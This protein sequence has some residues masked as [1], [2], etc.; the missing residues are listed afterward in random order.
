MGC[1]EWRVSRRS[2]RAGGS[3]VA[4][5]LS[6]LAAAGVAA[7]AASGATAATAST[8][9]PFV[10][11]GENTCTGEAFNAAGKLHLVLGESVSASGNVQSHLHATLRGVE[12]TT[13]TGAKYV[14]MTSD[15]MTYTFDALDLAPFV[16][17]II[18]TVQY[19]RSG[20]DGAVLK[21]DDFYQQIVAHVTVNS[22]GV[23]TV[24]RFTFDTRCR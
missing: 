24:D 9:A 23:V 11:A 22:N 13:V 8:S 14:V 16:T 20:E 6:A 5:A 1:F 15:T 3:G 19:V 7:F 21:G 10:Y 4:F 18:W 2:G 17:T 12:G